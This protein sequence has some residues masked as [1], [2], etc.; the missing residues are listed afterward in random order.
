MD[1]ERARSDLTTDGRLRAAINIGNPILAQV[2]GDT[3]RGVTVDLARELARRLDAPLDLV[4]FSSARYVVESVRK[5]AL[6]IVFLAIDP[7]RANE[8][9][10]SAPYVLLE[11][12]YVVRDNA[13]VRT[14][15]DLDLTRSAIGVVRGSAYDLHLTAALKNATIV[16]YAAHEDA[17]AA[18]RDGHLTALAGIR[19]PMTDLAS[20][21]PGLRLI[22]TP[23]MTIRQAMAVPKGRD[24][25][26]AYLDL[27]LEE[28][29]NSGFIADALE[30][31]GQGK[32]AT[33]P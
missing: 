19:Q 12:N 5:E 20:R 16:R 22:E 9:S 26:L 32:A 3:V 1:I 7:K 28:M 33:I 15:E 29:R 23:F 24:A 21:D 14:N 2:D 4:Q 11:G 13:P 8:L 18:F 25:G 27:F 6:N 17:V 31:S 30:R 10:F